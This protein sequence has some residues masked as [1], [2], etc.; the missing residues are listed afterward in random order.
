MALRREDGG[1]SLEKIE[2]LADLGVR[3]YKTA[4]QIATLRARKKK[5]FAQTLP[6]QI[7]AKQKAA[8]QWETMYQQLIHFKNQH[9]KSKQSSA[10]WGTAEVNSHCIYSIQH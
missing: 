10:E 4:S 7:I 8:Q 6:E 3:P 5:I 2:R 9:G 1:L